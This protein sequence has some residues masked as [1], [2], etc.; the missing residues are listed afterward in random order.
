MRN[1]A[2]GAVEA[3][4]GIA[5]GFATIAAADTVPDLGWQPA[6]R[7]VVVAGA[8]C[9]VAV[10][11]WLRA[12]AIRTGR[13]GSRSNPSSHPQASDQSIRSLSRRFRRD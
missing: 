4:A 11:A 13:P 6:A 2:R 1:A 7:V 5:F 3:A 9:L 10:L 12:R 8:V